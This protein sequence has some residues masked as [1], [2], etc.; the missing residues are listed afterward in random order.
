MAE[1][2]LLVHG[3]SRPEGHKLFDGPHYYLLRFESYSPRR[4][5]LEDAA[6]TLCALLRH[7]F[8]YSWWMNRIIAFNSAAI[9]QRLQMP[10]ER[11]VAELLNPDFVAAMDAFEAD[12][13]GDELR[14]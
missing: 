2:Y 8:E 5:L 1:R 12:E 11:D 13:L 7:R 4:Q 3:R 9:H 6:L 10:V 14:D